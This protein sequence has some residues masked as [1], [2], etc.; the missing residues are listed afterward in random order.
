M[1]LLTLSTAT[2]AKRADR[3]ARRA[4]R[5][6]RKKTKKTIKQ[7]R[8]KTRR[9]RRASAIRTLAKNPIIREIANIT[10]EEAIKI[11]EPRIMEVIKTESKDKLQ[12]AFDMIDAIPGLTDNEKF[13]ILKRL[14]NV[15]R[16]EINKLPILKNI[17]A[18]NSYEDMKAVVN[19]IE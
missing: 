15:K 16:D 14:L 3:Q 10:K 12:K 6:E 13:S 9:E 7:K 4:E 18:A 5:Q 8:R 2:H 11:A 1:S 19:A 17:A